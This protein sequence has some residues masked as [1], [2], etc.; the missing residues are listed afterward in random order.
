MARWDP[1]REFTRMERDMRRMLDNFFSDIW[2]ERSRR[3]I[4]PGPR[5]GVETPLAEREEG[6]IG[7][8]PVDLADKGDTLVLRSEMPGV[9]KDDIKISVGE[10]EITVSGKVQRSKEEKDENYYYS[11]R[12]YNSW[13][14]TI[15]L[16]AR[17]KSDKAKAKYE[18][19]ILE[20]TLPKTEEEKEKKKEIK[21][22]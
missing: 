4:L 2:G 17:V 16:P 15:P 20:V 22:E 21:V 3:G 10:D 7:T 12:A 14:R 1:F 8:P 5:R 11:E 18:D 9:K 19:G 6:M 13:Q